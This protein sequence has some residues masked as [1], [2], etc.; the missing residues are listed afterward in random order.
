MIKA[1]DLVVVAGEANEVFTVT[2]VRKGGKSVVLSTGWVEPIE[3]CV[4]IPKSFHKD[5]HTVTTR[6][7][8]FD[9]MEAILTN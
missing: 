6:H 2:L 8:N 5:I 1:G 7:I 3:K 9:I 4:K